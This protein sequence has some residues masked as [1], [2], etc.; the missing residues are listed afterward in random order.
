MSGVRRSY[1]EQ[2]QGAQMYLMEEDKKECLDL[3]SFP[4]LRLDQ[5]PRC[6][7][8]VLSDARE[9]LGKLMSVM[10]SSSRHLQSYM[11][12][13]YDAMN[14]E[15]EKRRIYKKKRRIPG[16][17]IER[18]EEKKI[19]LHSF[20]VSSAPK[21]DDEEIRRNMRRKRALQ[22]RKNKRDEALKRE[23]ME[24]K[25][26]KLRKRAEIREKHNREMRVVSRKVDREV[27][28]DREAVVKSEDGVVLEDVNTRRRSCTKTPPPVP[29]RRGR[30]RKVCVVTTKEKEMLLPFAVQNESGKNIK[31]KVTKNCFPCI[32]QNDA[33]HSIKEKQHIKRRQSSHRNNVLRETTENIL[34]VQNDDRNVEDDFTNDMEEK[35]TQKIDSL[36]KR[37]LP[38]KRDDVNTKQVKRIQRTARTY[39]KRRRQRDATIRI[40]ELIRF[41][42]ICRFVRQHHDAATSVQK[43][44]RRY[45]HQRCYYMLRHAIIF[46]Q[47]KCRVMISKTQV[48]KQKR[49]IYPGLIALQSKCR[50]IICK[51]QVTKRKRQIYPG[52]IALQSKCRVMMSKNQVTKR[53]RQIEL[54]VYDYSKIYPTMNFRALLCTNAS[55][56]DSKH[57]WIEHLSR[58]EKDLVLFQ[59]SHVKSNTLY[60]DVVRTRS[61][62]MELL[63]RSLH[64]FYVGGSKQWEDAVS[65]AGGQS[66]WNLLWTWK[67]PQIEWHSILPWQCVNHFPQ[68]H[69]LTRK[70][71]LRLS[72]RHFHGLSK[73]V[74]AVFRLQPA[75]FVLPREY[76]A[77]VRAFNIDNDDD[78]NTSSKE[79]QTINN[80]WI[81]KPARSSRGRGIRLVTDL[82]DVQYSESVVIQKYITNPLLLDGYKFDL[83][84]YVLVTSFQPL[85]AFLYQDGFAR[86]ALDKFNTQDAKALNVHLTNSSVQQDRDDMKTKLAEM[87]PFLNASK[88]E[89]GGSKM[90]TAEL[91]RQ[92]EHVGHDVKKI[93]HGIREC[94][95]KSLMSVN[96]RIKSQE[97]S[98]EIFGYDILIDTDLRSWLIEVNSSPS[99]GCSNALDIR[100]KDSLIR[101]TLELLNPI[102]F[103]RARLL[104]F[105]RA[106][107]LKAKG[108]SGKVEREL[109][110]T[111]FSKRKDRVKLKWNLEISKM[112]Q[113][114][115]PRKYGEIPGKMGR[116]IRL[117]PDTKL[118][119]KYLQFLKEN[120]STCREK[121]I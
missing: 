83:R 70:D 104:R 101:D 76:N 95:L 6:E 115:V 10:D 48:T 36:D 31:E 84:L 12:R 1:D 24:R 97:S 79:K 14:V 9:Q 93:K 66:L 2:V 39:I 21:E 42:R 7:T 112:L 50:V 77:F 35:T 107:L 121:D 34:S 110:G 49:Q 90:S 18:N 51:N 103:D 80:W 3:E 60:Y 111:S 15:I 37:K 47:S 106:A 94:V 43:H 26:D 105:V 54:S 45:L 87:R 81:M 113:K 100:I 41:I 119:S 38:K 29:E 73:R 99:L 58:L 16:K 17:K 59:E 69:A 67:K 55:M 91:W 5:I 62:L 85:E 65:R 11:K 98:F 108:R 78:D 56:F 63:R 13:Q 23:E 33:N 22:K 89:V 71:N 61:E 44:I 30:S 28:V 64:D 92:L 74:A 25:R 40:Q 88:D 117:C 19:V 116:Y 27:D 4:L 72:L 102:P 32:V 114:H 68:T 52:L 57:S 75:T 96:H 8:R 20:V 86:F 120:T 109:F 46:L 53:K 82:D 118:H